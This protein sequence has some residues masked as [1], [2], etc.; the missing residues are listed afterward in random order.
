MKLSKK[1]R[2]WNEDQIKKGKPPEPKFLIWL[3]EHGEDEES[4]MALPE[5][6]CYTCTNPCR[7]KCV[8][9]ENSE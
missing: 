7:E 5:E 3:D 2:Q 6:R 1:W 8:I 9:G 4:R